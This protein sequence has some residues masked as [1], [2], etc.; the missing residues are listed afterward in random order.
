MIFGLIFPFG[1]LF[2]T[3]PSGTYTYTNTCNLAMSEQ[4]T[5]G[6]AQGLA[7]EI[8]DF[9]GMRCDEHQSISAILV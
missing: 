2:E 6:K 7:Y 1:C 9:K 5:A 4:E 8:P 3:T